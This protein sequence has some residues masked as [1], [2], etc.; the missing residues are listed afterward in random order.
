[1][2]PKARL[3]MARNTSKSWTGVGG[4]FAAQE[5][6]LCG[7]GCGQYGFR[8][9]TGRR[10]LYLNDTHKKRVMR[11]QRKARQETSTAHLTPNGW[12]YF[13]TKD[14]AL[15]QEIWDSLTLTEQE[16]VAVMCN[17]GMKPQVFIDAVLS[18]FALERGGKR[19]LSGN[20]SFD[21]EGS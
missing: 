2:S 11:A 14:D 4:L 9:A 1:M 13:L 3:K 21:Y 15:L 18:L 7:C 12:L 6:F 16:I 8:R 20:R 17:R 19:E 5:Q 10:R